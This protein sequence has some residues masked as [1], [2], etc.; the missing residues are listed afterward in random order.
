MHMNE[1][2][3]MAELASALALMGLGI[4]WVF[5][6]TRRRAFDEFV[7]RKR[8]V[9]DGGAVSEVSVATEKSA[10]VARYVGGENILCAGGC[11][12]TRKAWPGEVTGGRCAACVS[13]W[14]GDGLR[15]DTRRAQSPRD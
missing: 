3:F 7:R 6:W 8:Q 4:L 9:V 1:Q 11:G 13:P 12:A 5:V 14:S 15:P 10:R 2:E